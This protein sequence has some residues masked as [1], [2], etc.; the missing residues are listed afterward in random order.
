MTTGQAGELNAR[1]SLLDTRNSEGCQL[2]EAKT[3]EDM[4]LGDRRAMN[5]IEITG[6]AV[7]VGCESGCK[8]NF[9]LA[10]G[11]TRS[12][13]FLIDGGSGQNMRLGVGQGVVEWVR[14][15][16]RGIGWRVGDCEYEVGNK[17]D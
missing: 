15:R 17:Q 16:V 12:Q 8:P 1:P 3:I 11:R 7:F 10:G 6:A 2:I 13:M 5:L 9:S 14:G 4:P